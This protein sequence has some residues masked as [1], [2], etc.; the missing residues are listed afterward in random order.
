MSIVGQ[1][2]S[3]TLLFK[4]EKKTRN[5]VTNAHKMTPPPGLPCFVI[6]YFLVGNLKINLI[7]VYNRIWGMSS[8]KTYKDDEIL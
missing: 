1:L 6:A 8:Y 5:T 4:I 7:K 3:P 2:D